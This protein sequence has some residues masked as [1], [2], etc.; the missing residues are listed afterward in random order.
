MIE[1]YTGRVFDSA[2]YT[3]EAYD[4]NDSEFIVLNQ[5]PV[6]A[7]SAVKLKDDAGNTTTYETT[8][9]RYEA[10]NGR[11]YRLGAVRGRYVTDTFGAT[12]NPEF[13]VYPCWPGGFQN[14]LVTYTAGY[15][16]MPA[17]L[18][19][20]MYMLVDVLFSETIGG[21]KTLD[22]SITSETLGDYSYTRAHREMNTNVML[23][24]LVNQFRR[25][26]G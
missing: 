14:I 24:G 9:Y 19:M 10:A 17:D 13:G 8:D 16:S 15:S 4:G 7:L 5:Y 22:A 20:A 25:F 12:V 18:Q 3:D 1:R 23:Q 21:T 26:W 11:L 6:T 2:T